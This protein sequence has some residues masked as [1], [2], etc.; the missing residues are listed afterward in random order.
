[1]PNWVWVKGKGSLMTGFELGLLQVRPQKPGSQEGELKITRRL[2]FAMW[3]GGGGPALWHQGGD[4]PTSWACPLGLWTAFGAFFPVLNMNTCSLWD[5]FVTPFPA[6]RIPEVWQ[7][8]FILSWLC[9]L[10]TRLALFLLRWVF[11][12][13]SHMPNLCGKWLSSGTLGV[14]SRACCHVFTTWIGWVFSKSSSSGSF[15]LL[16]F[17]SL[18]LHLPISSKEKPSCAFN[19]LLRNLFN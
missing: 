16:Q 12:S 1:M 15:L 7:P 14:V 11:R 2:V 8:S 9:P 17:I 19:T 3:N 6:S 5:R 10:Q 18:L 13:T 4:S